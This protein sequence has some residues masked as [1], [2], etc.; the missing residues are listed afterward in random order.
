MNLA[1]HRKEFFQ[2]ALD[3]P[4][5]LPLSGEDPSCRFATNGACRYRPVIEFPE[6]S[7]RI[8]P[9]SLIGFNRNG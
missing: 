7:D 1:N 3:D 2:V 9:K 4:R 5:I 8:P 6:I